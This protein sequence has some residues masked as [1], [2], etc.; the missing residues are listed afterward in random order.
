VEP[1][2]VPRTAQVDE[3]RLAPDDARALLEYY[4][5]G[6]ERYSRAHALLTLAWY[7]GARLG[8]LRGLDLDDFDAEEQY[9]E[10]VHRA[11]DGT[12]LKNDRDGERMVGL[13]ADA[14]DVV[15]GYV[16]HERHDKH[17]ENGREPL[18]ASAAGRASENAVRAWMYLATVP[19]LHMDCPHGNDRDTCEYIDY[20]HAS[21]CPSSRSPHQVRTGSIT[22]Q[23][24]RG[25]P[26]QVVAE[27]VN[28]SVRTLK[29]H[30]DQPNK[31]EELESRRREHVD[32]LG[33]GRGGGN[34]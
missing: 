25:V 2:E 16:E 23:L 5:N 27:R 12:P 26:L 15:A 11:R 34:R 29:K 28:T 20:N 22:W 33:F 1:P 31:R 17:D 10:F 6:E 3:K 9:V 24:N 4:G 30:Y 21:K 13:P 19:C 8:G 7:T 32:D 18:L 14:A